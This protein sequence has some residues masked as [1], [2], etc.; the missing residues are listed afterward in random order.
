M[1][2]NLLSELLVGLGKLFLNPFTYIFFIAS[3]FSGNL[4]VKRER[5][6]FSVRN[7]NVTFEWKTS[8]GYGLLI[9]LILSVITLVAGIS[10]PI[11]MVVS[12][13]SFWTSISST[14][15]TK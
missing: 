15:I 3:I 13:L 7:F 6:H 5:K 8:L 14:A 4:R 12:C 2:S 11:E 9:G 1:W 10:I